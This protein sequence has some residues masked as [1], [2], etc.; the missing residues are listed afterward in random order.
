MPGKNHDTKLFARFLLYCVKTDLLRYKLVSRAW[1]AMQFMTG[2]CKNI[3]MYV[4]R[5]HDGNYNR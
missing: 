1:K 5:C 3:V 4:S 2:I